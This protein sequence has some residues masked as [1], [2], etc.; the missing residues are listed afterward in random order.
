[1]T[2]SFIRKHLFFDLS[3]NL[4]PNFDRPIPRGVFG[5][6]TGMLYIKIS[7][8]ISAF[9]RKARELILYKLEKENQ[10]NKT[11]ESLTHAIS[12]EEKNYCSLIVLYGCGGLLRSCQKK[13]RV[14]SIRTPY[15][16]WILLDFVFFKLSRPEQIRGADQNARL[17]VPILR[18]VKYKM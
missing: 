10:N 3:W 16:N 13:I 15:G 8:I 9:Q 5:N 1:M 4:T 7:V 17:F 6:R 11:T 18:S 14:W 12:N 2:I